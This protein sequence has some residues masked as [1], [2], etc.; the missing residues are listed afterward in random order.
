MCT[1]ART[2]GTLRIDTIYELQYRPNVVIIEDTQSGRK[3][4]V[5]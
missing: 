5:L 4:F 1:E 3:G 2:G